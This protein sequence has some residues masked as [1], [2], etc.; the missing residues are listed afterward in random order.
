MGQGCLS[1]QVFD[2]NQAVRLTIQG[3]DG[4]GRV[5]N[6]P[7]GRLGTALTFQVGIGRPLG[8]YTVTVR[9]GTRVAKAIFSLEATPTAT[10]KIDPTIGPPGTTFKVTLAT[11]PPN[12]GLHIYRLAANNTDG[13]SRWEYV[14][15]LPMPQVNERG[16]AFITFQTHSDDPLG[17]YR[18][19]AEVAV[20]QWGTRNG[21]AIFSLK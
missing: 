13:S 12:T 10:M 6:F 14:S 5:I 4:I 7:A 1:A 9:Q 20:S 21:E 2:R 3:P 19:V 15:A 11:F 17:I 16:E 18:L 8:R